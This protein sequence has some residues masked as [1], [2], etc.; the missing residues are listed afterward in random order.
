VRILNATFFINKNNKNTTLFIHWTNPDK[1][2]F[3][4]LY[5]DIVIRILFFGKSTFG[6]YNKKVKL[7]F[8]TFYFIKLHPS[9]HPSPSE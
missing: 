4:L 8:R 1:G 5:G 3:I 9:T 2:L 7:K 6:K